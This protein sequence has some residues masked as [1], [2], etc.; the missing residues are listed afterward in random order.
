MN[1]DVTQQMISVLA[2]GVID[3]N[4]NAALELL[5]MVLTNR[6]QQELGLI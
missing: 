4:L 1:G 5:L 3:I 6:N 2:K